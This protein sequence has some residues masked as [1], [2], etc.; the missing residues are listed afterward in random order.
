M[1]ASPVC[2]FCYR[3][4]PGDLDKVIKAN[5]VPVSISEKPKLTV[6]FCALQQA[7]LFNATEQSAL[8][9]VPLRNTTETGNR[10]HAVGFANGGS[11]PHAVLERNF[12]FQSRKARI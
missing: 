2:L 3:R 10:P 5:G 9:A 6:D 11:G 4:F 8:A 1:G 7:G 12:A